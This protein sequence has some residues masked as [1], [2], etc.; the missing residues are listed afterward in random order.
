MRTFRIF[1]WSGNLQS[2]QVTPK[3]RFKKMGVLDHGVEA[4]MK[5]LEMKND[6]NNA[7]NIYHTL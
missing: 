4:T 6:W 3:S 1:M 5:I 2:I 7:I